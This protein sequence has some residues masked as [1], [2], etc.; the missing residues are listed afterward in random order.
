MFQNNY[1]KS[2]NNKNI[3][4]KN[5]KYIV[6]VANGTAQLSA[7]CSAGGTASH[8]SL[9]SKVLFLHITGLLKEAKT[10]DT[11][12]SDTSDSDTS[13]VSD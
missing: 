3:D 10:S 11:S 6:K 8:W 9:V 4:I 7:K 1:K 5:Y 2:Q 12:D 13:A